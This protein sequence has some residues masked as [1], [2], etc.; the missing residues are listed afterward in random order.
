MTAL[1]FPQSATMKVRIFLLLLLANLAATPAARATI[2]YSGIQDF[3]IPLDLEGTYLRLDTGATAATFPA[4]WSA[5]P[6]INPFFGG[7]DIGTSPLLR[8]AIT[9]PDQILNLAPGTLISS[10]SNFAAGQSGSSTHVGS[11]PGQFTLNVPGY[12]GIAFRSTVGGPDSYGWLQIEIHNLGP[13]KIIAWAYEDVSGAS[14]QAGASSAPEP[15]VLVLFGSAGAA[16]A[17]TRRRR[18]LGGVN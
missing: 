15:G 5:A 18:A 14:I 8:P 9:G 12:L 2:I 4:D 1:L 7:V 6:W 13:G 11:G 3:P 17:L 16:L 10:A